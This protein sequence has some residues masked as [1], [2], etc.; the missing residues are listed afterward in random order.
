GRRATAN[1]PATTVIHTR[2]EKKR[3]DILTILLF[4][5]ATR[6]RA[7]PRHEPHAR[8]TDQSAQFM[9]N[10]PAS[11]NSG[12][13]PVELPAVPSKARERPGSLLPLAP[14]SV[15]RPLYR[16]FVSWSAP[17]HFFRTVPRTYQG[18]H[19]AQIDY[20]QTCCAQRQVSFL[21]RRA[22]LMRFFT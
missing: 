17:Y 11:E 13:F 14:C 5:R 6:A 16:L 9:P 7:N 22:A 3:L 15:S 20:L 12:A 2:C 21:Y 19:D 18:T 10:L 8:F 4:L 1:R